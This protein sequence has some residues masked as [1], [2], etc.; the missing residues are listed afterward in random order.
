MNDKSGNIFLQN[1]DF[2]VR[3]LNRA[4]IL[5][6]YKAYEPV[7]K[8]VVFFGQ[9]LI[10]YWCFDGHCYVILLLYLSFWISCNIL[11][12]DYFQIGIIIFIKVAITHLVAC[13]RYSSKR[14]LV[15][16]LPMSRRFTLIFVHLWR[17][18]CIK[19]SFLDVIFHIVDKFEY[20]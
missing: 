19:R 7:M 20:L 15:Q 10:S 1:E 2:Y 3:L 6:Q 13:S 5:L 8:C 11:L 16:G 4:Y 17:P 9:I 14:I 18:I 12:L